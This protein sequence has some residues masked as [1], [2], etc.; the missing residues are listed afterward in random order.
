MTLLWFFG[1]VA[2]LVAGAWVQ[3]RW[4]RSIAARVVALMC[5]AWF[6]GTWLALF[7]LS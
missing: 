5:S 4:P 3:D 6:A 1:A 7:L 2:V